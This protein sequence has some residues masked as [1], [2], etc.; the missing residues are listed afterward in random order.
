M[1]DRWKERRKERGD[2]NSTS[3]TKKTGNKREN[4]NKWREVM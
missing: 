3:N 2:D 4:I 1:F